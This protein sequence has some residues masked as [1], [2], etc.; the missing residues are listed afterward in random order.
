PPRRNTSMYYDAVAGRAVLVGGENQ[1]DVWWYESG[2]WSLA[3]SGSSPWSQVRVTYDPHRGTG[4]GYGTGTGVGLP[5]FTVGSEWVAFQPATTNLTWGAPVLDIEGQP[6][7][8]P[9]A[10]DLIV[11]ELSYG[12]YERLAGWSMTTP[13]SLTMGQGSAAVWD[14]DL[15]VVIA[16]GGLQVIPPTGFPPTFSYEY[17]NTTWHFDPTSSTWSNQG[18]SAPRGRVR[19]ILTYVPGRGTYLFGGDRRPGTPRNSPQRRSV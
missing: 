4:Y 6:A 9:G 18:A 13:S 19:G 7:H 3:P 12:T 8:A 1:S 16:F 11:S 14:P 5:E 15:G 17:F 2:D 10:H